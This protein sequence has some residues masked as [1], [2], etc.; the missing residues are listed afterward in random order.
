MKKIIILSML[1]F[2]VLM[3]GCTA[4]TTKGDPIERV[5]KIEKMEKHTLYVKANNWMVDTFNDAKSVVQFTDKESG[6]IS[7]RY[8]L[9][10]IS[11]ASQYGPAR[12][13]Y[14]SIKIKVKD[15]ASKI[16][17]TPE[18]FTYMKG[19]MYS[20]YSEQEVKRDVD[21]LLASFES[22][23]KEKDDSDW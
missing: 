20:L 9:G 22:S 1:C 18:S 19:N 4:I 14:A 12:Y 8:L 17:V 3:Q 15:N 6:T 2:V 13:A 11:A 23:M 21:A 10:T 16:V 7:G 5:V